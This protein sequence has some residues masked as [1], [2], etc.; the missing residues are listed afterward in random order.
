[1]ISS[2]IEWL[3][4]VGITIIVILILAIL[5]LG[6]IVAVASVNSSKINHEQEIFE[7]IFETPKGEG[8]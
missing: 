3:G 4:P 8:E 5:L 7:K 2:A 1:M 6:V